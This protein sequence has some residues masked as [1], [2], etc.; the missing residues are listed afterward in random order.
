MKW[1]SLCYSG[2]KE[3]SM[4]WILIIVTF[5]DY[6][7]LESFLLRNSLITNDF[8]GFSVKSVTSLEDFSFLDVLFWEYFKYLMVSG[9]YFKLRV[10]AWN[11]FI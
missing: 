9:K 6:I 2:Q 5:E 7:C 11:T 8:Y 3:Q 4:W 10:I 1:K